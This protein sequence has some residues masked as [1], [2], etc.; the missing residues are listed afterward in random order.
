MTYIYAAF[1]ILIR[2]VL[3]RTILRN[4]HF[5][6]LFGQGASSLI[7]LAMMYIIFNFMP[8]A[9]AGIWFLLQ[10]FV[11]TCEAARYGLLS[12][13]TVKFYAGTDKDRAATVLG[14]IWFIALTFSAILLV[15]N[16]LALFYLPYT[17]NYELSLCIKWIGLTYLSTVPSDI[18]FWKLQADEQYTK[19][20][21]FRLINSCGTIG[22]FIILALLHKFTLENVI[23]WNFITN[24]I[25]SVMGLIWYRSGI[26]YLSKRTKECVSEIFH[27]GKYT[28]GTTLLSKLLGDSN[29]WI[30]SFVLG[31]AAVAIY[32]L[33]MKFIA[34]IEMPL[35]AFATTGMSEMAIANNTNNL[36]LV[37]YLFKKYAGMI[38]ITFIPF[39]ILGCILADI[40]IHL[41]GGQNF[42][43][44][45]GDL[46]ANLF[47]FALILALAYPT[48][49]FNGLA[50]DIT[51]HTK[52]NFHKMVLVVSTKIIVALT[53]TEILKNLYG[54]VIANYV[55]VVISLIYG[56]YQL[57]KYIPHSF[58]GILSIGYKEVILFLQ[59]RFNFSK[60]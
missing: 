8:L 17:T 54:I 32:Q 47:R 48:D 9:H 20:I 31:P 27:Y 26:K 39:A 21:W 33:G 41:L 12:T 7:G 14:S 2:K 15:I 51:H 46:A 29:I 37:G 16:G 43:G 24:C 19:M 53:A 59:R 38:T 36:E 58:T 40:P 22:S 25:P 10:S 45:S 49:Q 18:V 56:H 30:I 35:R 13:A 50:L 57:R 4:K 44:A 28:L 42:S 11:G 3:L 52:T 6:V 55:S 60:R 1:P 23:L 5:I 34:Y